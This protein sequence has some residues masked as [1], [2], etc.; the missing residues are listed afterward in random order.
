MKDSPLVTDWPAVIRHLD[1][2]GFTPLEI[3]R[4]TGMDQDWILKVLGKPNP[5]LEQ[6]TNK[7][8]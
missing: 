1:K 8:E 6:L 3:E 5:F 4:R 2:K 7:E